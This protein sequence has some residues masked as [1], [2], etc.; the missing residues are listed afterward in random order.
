MSL[1]EIQTSGYSDPVP[2]LVSVYIIC[3]KTNAKVHKNLS[4]VIPS[5]ICFH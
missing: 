1:L 4:F 3:F 2:G 5:L